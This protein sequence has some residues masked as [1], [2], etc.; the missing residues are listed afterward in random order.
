MKL[1]RKTLAWVPAALLTSYMTGDNV[2]C[3]LVF[4]RRDIFLVACVGLEYETVHT[5]R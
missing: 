5:A 1:G 2:V 3:F 4:K